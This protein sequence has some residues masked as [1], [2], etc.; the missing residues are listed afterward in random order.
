M[1]ILTKTPKS[2]PASL[3]NTSQKKSNT[4]RKEY[5]KHLHWKRLEKNTHSRKHEHKDKKNHTNKRQKRSN[6]QRRA[7]T[8]ATMFEFV[9]YGT[10]KI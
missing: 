5:V 4:T 6:L 7:V 8:E 3:L 9:W 1:Q 10:A 2:I